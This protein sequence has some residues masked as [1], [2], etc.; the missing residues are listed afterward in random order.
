MIPFFRKTRKKLADD[1]KPMKYTRYAIGEIL[2][3]VIGILIALQINNWNEERKSK[4]TEINVLND[5]VLGLEADRW[6]MDYIYDKHYK[7][8]QSCEIILQ[9]I[10]D[11]EEGNNLLGE[12]FAA[13]NNFTNFYAT[14]GAYESLKTIGF[15]IITNKDLRFQI[16]NLYEQWYSIIQQNLGTHEESIQ[17]LVPFYQDH[18][19]KFS[20]V[21][22]DT[23]VVG[24]SYHGVMNPIDMGSLMKN[25]HYKYWVN[26]LNA[27]HQ[28][29]LGMII[30]IQKRVDKLIDD[31]KKE[32]LLLS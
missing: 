3:V 24:F 11:Y 12:Q 23:S 28:T 26:T 29:L 27:N 1:N 20:F 19:D 18:F 31:I 8:I 5:L 2:L 7:A 10:E 4:V 6:T 17:G 13:I 21:K 9:K 25:Q 22:K 30:A 16:I 15:E 14:R 32:I